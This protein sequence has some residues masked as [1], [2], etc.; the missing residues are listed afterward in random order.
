M[1]LKRVPPRPISVGTETSI[2][3]SLPCSLS[4]A[5]W[6]KQSQLTAC[7]ASSSCP[8]LLVG[9]DRDECA[10]YNYN[11]GNKF[12]P[13]SIGIEEVTLTDIDLTY[14]RVNSPKLVENVQQQVHDYVNYLKLDDLPDGYTYGLSERASSFEKH[15][16]LTTARLRLEFY[17]KKRRTWL[18]VN[19]ECSPWEIWNIELDVVRAEDFTIMREEVGEKLGE[20][21]LNICSIVN[22]P[23][24]IP[25]TPTIADLPLVFDDRF[26]DIQ[27]YLF[28]LVYNKVVYKMS[29]PVQIDVEKNSPPSNERLNA[30]RQQVH[31]VKNIMTD[32]VVRIMERG[33]RLE[34]LDSRTEALHA[35][36]QTF[37]TTARQVQRK[38]CLKSLKWTIILGVV[39]FLVIALIVI[40]ILDGSG[41]FDNN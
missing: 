31:D 28:R 22:Q 30:V 36:S 23:C 7:D 21:V 8:S 4:S 2:E 12:S 26:S 11:E 29:S 18:A 27:P 35:S 15:D 37:Q 25:S 16:P 17:Q 33:D 32:N 13:G 40:L 34:D 38:M 5:V 39:V 1:D 14:V 24:Y 3:L 20:T 19:D 41:A 6:A 9:V 10:R